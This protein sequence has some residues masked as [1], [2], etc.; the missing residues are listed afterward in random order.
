MRIGTPND[1]TRT[2]GEAQGYQPLPVA[3]KVMRMSVEGK[4]PADVP[5]MFTVWH[6]TPAE[7]EALQA[8]GHVVLGV[9]GTSHPPVMLY[10]AN[11]EGVV[12]DDSVQV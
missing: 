1:V 6:P 8:G 3:D 2:L 12:L 11:A 4:E 10:C 9:L 7:I 5:V